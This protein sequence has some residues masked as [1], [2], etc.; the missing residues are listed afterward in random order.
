MRILFLTH[1]YPNYVPDL[2]LHGLRKLMGANVVDYPR[3]DCL[4]DGVLGLGVCTPDQRCPGWF[5]NDHGQ[6]DRSDIWHKARSGFFDIVVSDLRAIG[7]L[8][9]HLDTWPRHSVVIDGE[10]KPYPLSPGPYVVCRRETDGSDFSIPLPMAL[11]EEIF[12]WIRRYDGLAKRYSIGFLGSSHND[13][14]KRFIEALSTHYPDALLYSTALP[15]DDNPCPDGRVGRDQYYRKLQ[16][17]KIVLSLPGAGNDTFR[18]W[19]HAACNALHAAASAPLYIPCDFDSNQDIIRFSGLDEL[20]K[21]IDAIVHDHHRCK[22]QIRRSRDKLLT[23]HMTSKR[24]AYF[25]ER[26]GQAFGT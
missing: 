18:F 7:Q 25:L 5:Q 1:P 2:L 3:K 8:S 16:Q 9:S 11:P 12:N 22:E 15:R 13:T 20:R 14:R 6:I 21:K 24:A 10:D 4:Y 23:F 26:V 19:E 17:C